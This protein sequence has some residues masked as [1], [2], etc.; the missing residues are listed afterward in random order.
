ML[1]RTLVE[2][3]VGDG[4]RVGT[5]PVRAE[6]AAAVHL[7]L[8]NPVEDAVLDV[9]VAV[10]GELPLALGGDVDDVDVVAANERDGASVGAERHFLFRAGRGGEARHGVAVEGVDVN[11]VGDRQQNAF[12]VL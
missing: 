10:G 12:L 1:Y 4:R 6:V 5:P 9:L 2:L 8:I 11:V 7:F 3:Q